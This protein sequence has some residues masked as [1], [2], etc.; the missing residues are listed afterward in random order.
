M[1]DIEKRKRVMQ[2]SIML[3]HCICNPKKACPCDIFKQKDIC[4]CAGE[5]VEYAIEEVALTQLVEKAGCASKI[6]QN[7]LKKVLTGLPEI[8]DPRVLVGTNTCDDAGVFALDENTALVQTV[9]V[10]T[11]G[12]DDPYTFGQIAAANSLSDVYAM[13]GKPLTALSIIGF[14]IETLSPRV[15][16][17]MLRGGMDKMAEAGVPI[18]GG[19]SIND[20]NPKFGYAVTGVVNPSKIVTNDGAKP[21][22]VLILT[23]PIGVGFISFANQLGRA[24]ESVIAAASRSMTELNKTAAE[25]MVEVGVNSATDV[26]GFGLLGHLSEM[27]AQSGVTAEVYADQVPIFDEVMDYASQGMISGGVE[28]NR[29]YAAGKVTANGISEE[30]L[31]ILCDPQ[32][33]G[34]LLMSVSQAKVAPLL[35]QLRARGVIQACVIG[36]VLPKSDTPVIV[37]EQE[38][39]IKLDSVIQEE[40]AAMAEL[41]SEDCCGGNGHECCASGPDLATERSA[42]DV[43]SKFGAFMREVNGE[44]AIPVRTKEL[45][46]IALSLLSKCEPCIKIHIDKAR[47]IGVSEEEIQEAVWMAISFGGAPT[48][49]FY[50]SVMGKE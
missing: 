15:M 7:D 49:M 6:N 2:R 39:S 12:V 50:E 21:G 46:A 33:S 8:N 14:P 48:M 3:G 5:R 42:I 10:F 37:K 45:I 36:A 13:G 26:T 16:T 35:S 11:P 17:Q 31:S 30:M 41:P 22:D 38:S 18:V 28:R 47:S 1:I 20:E 32:T 23:K 25:V 34:G 29:E 40:A 43:A 44:G 19:H 24:S 4:P 27:A 9:D